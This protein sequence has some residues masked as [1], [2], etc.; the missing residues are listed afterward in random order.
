MTTNTDE[1]VDLK[2]TL[3]DQGEPVE[4]RAHAGG[5]IEA[6]VK[7]LGQFDVDVRVLDYSEHAMGQ[8][9]DAKAASYVE[10]TVNGQILW[11][12]GIDSSITRATYKAVISAV[13]RALR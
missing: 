2:V 13:N 9:G 3:K 6:F 7:A 11:G 8:G 12:V 4:V 10:A 5:P 1:Q